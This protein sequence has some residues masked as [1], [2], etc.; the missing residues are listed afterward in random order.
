VLFPVP[1]LPPDWPLRMQA[2]VNAGSLLPLDQGTLFDFLSDD[3]SE[4]GVDILRVI[5]E[6]F[7]RCRTWISL[8]NTYWT[9]R[10]KFRNAYNYEARRLA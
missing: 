3:I 6:T 4:C 7:N 9:S 8:S 10:I 1:N 2:F 5:K